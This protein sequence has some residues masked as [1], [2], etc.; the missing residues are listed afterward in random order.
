MNGNGSKNKKGTVEQG[1]KLERRVDHV[2]KND[3]NIQQRGFAGRHRP[4]Y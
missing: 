3:K 2:Y 1:V 4:N